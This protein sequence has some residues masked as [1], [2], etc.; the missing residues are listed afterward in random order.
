M[1]VVV[2]G[3]PRSGTSLMM[4]MLVAG[5]LV[6]FADD[7][8]PADASNP[9]GY[10]EHAR[11]KSLLSDASWVPEADGHVLKVVAPLL[12]RLP[13]GPAYRVVLM[14]RPIESVL[15]SQTAMLSRLGRPA[16]SGAALRPVFERHL[17]DAR[18]WAARAGDL[19]AV[20]HHD[21]VHSPESVAAT[22][23]AFVE[24]GTDLQLDRAAMAAV[25]DPRLHRERTP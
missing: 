12:P 8:R 25:A 21:A 3:L 19:L 16:A 14:E 4:Q 10:F 23:A 11:V 1:I 17:A 18:A 5:G 2:S 24:G 9:R 15:R 7:A 20:S 13:A 6:P 22:V